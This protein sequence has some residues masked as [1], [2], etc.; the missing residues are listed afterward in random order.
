MPKTGEF[1]S[2]W[3]SKDYAAPMPDNSGNFGGTKGGA[4][5]GGNS[6]KETG[7]KLG[8]KV[9]TVALG[10]VGVGDKVTSEKYGKEVATLGDGVRKPTRGGMKGK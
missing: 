9:T 2:L 5:V 1:K 10:G 4:S 3:P 7:D 6:D 8:A